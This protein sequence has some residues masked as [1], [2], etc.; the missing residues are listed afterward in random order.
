MQERYGSSLGKTWSLL[1]L[2]RCR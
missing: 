2:R 1:L